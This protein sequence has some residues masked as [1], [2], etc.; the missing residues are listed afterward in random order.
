MKRKRWLAALLAA[1]IA[2]APFALPSGEGGSAFVSQAEAFTS[3]SIQQDSSRPLVP[4]LTQTEY[5]YTID[6]VSSRYITLS[7]S[8][9]S[10]VT[11]RP[12]M[13]WDGTSVGRDTVRDMANS[14]VMNGRNVVAAVNGDMYNTS[15]GEPWGVVIQDG[16]LVHG[17]NVAG[18]DWLFFGFTK[19]GEVIY[20]D[21]S[22]YDQKWPELE[23]AIGLHC[24][25]VE[26]GANVCADK[27]ATRAPRTAVGVRRDGTVFFLAADGRQDSSIGLS[28]TELADLMIKEGA[29]WAGNL[30]GGGSTTVV[31]REI[32]SDR[33]TVQNT[34][35]DG[36]ERNVANCLLFIAPGSPTDAQ[37]AVSST[38][39]YGKV[40]SDTTNPVT[41]AP[42]KSYQFRMTLVSGSN[43]PDCY[44]DS[45]ENFTVSYVGREGRDYFYKVTAKETA[46]AGA[47]ATLYSIL[48]G[49]SGVSQCKVLTP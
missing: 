43:P 40:V 13:P 14:G 3:W 24:V 31:S 16:N 49:Q 34:P 2:A 41:I 37:K 36:S 26:N 7:V 28:L 18:R 20:G 35:S 1:A 30:D 11:V 21:K 42:G 38:D 45:T 29:V 47:S 5:S 15:T 8:P 10:G 4:G 46:S 6:G 48:P 25:L 32:G 33:L 27:S 12:A 22:V 39:L 44:L 23:Q 19:D 17:Y 9:D